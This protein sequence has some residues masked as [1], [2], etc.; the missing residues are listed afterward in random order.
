M[1]RFLFII[2]FAALSLTHSVR[3]QSEVKGSQA[4]N[5]V[6]FLVDDMGVMD[7]SLPF[8][9]DG[10]GKLKRYP[11]NDWYR[12]PSMERLASHGIRFSTFYAQ[13]V[14]SPTR[15]SIM[16]GQNATRHGTTTWI[17]PLGNNRGRNGPPKWNWE[18][19]KKGDVTLPRLLSAAGYK[20]IH[21]GKAHFGP[22]NYDGADPLKVGFDVNIAGACWGHP[23]S[24]YG[25]DYYGNHPKYKG[26]DGKRR[27]THNVPGLEKYHGTDTFLTE[28]LTIE[29]NAQLAVA[30]EEKRPF[31]LYMA[32]YAVHAPFQSDPRFAENYK[33][34][35]KGR[36][37]CAYATMIEGMDKSLGDILDQL[38][39]LGV[40]ENTLVFFLGDN[41]SDAPLGSKLGHASSA[42]LR[43]KK[44]TC[45]EGGTRVPFIAAWAKPNPENRWQKKLPILQGAVQG[46]FGSV[47]DIYPT[48]L[49][50][51]GVK[52]PAG[53][54]VDGCDLALQLSGTRNPERP[55]VFLM[56]FPHGPHNSSYFTSFRL[57]DW[58]LV[59]D[60]NPDGKEAPK[61]ALYNL[62][63][64]PF[65][66]EN[67]AAKNPEKLQQMIA[68]MSRQLEAENAL[69][70]VDSEGREL[71]PHSP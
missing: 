8:L 43:G 57:G 66:D 5:I 21:V 37:A 27:L 22:R 30:V 29:A 61:H 62:K 14:C 51:T 9:T 68:V 17:A 12:T 40:A 58:K 24:Y 15:V 32:H 49:D 10:N 38:D 36:G 34:S 56:H 2:V 11:L 6:V 47:M 20:T 3:G 59:Y 16:T 71:K 63:K 35:G 7:T 26:K 50:L 67:L 19:L 69:Y 28:A 46:Q 44:G 48:I 60:Y 65:E 55:G 45:Y 1:K 41:G 52:N 4:P 39:K 23:K 53:H 42:P 54:M 31:F 25:K 64:D 13:S 18:G 70:P 33:G